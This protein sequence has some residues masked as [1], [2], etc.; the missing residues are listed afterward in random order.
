MAKRWKLP[1]LVRPVGMQK[2]TWERKAEMEM[3]KGAHRVKGKEE[4]EKPMERKGL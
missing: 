3:D 4:G 1:Q 2:W